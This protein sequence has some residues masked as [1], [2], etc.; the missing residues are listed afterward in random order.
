MLAFVLLLSACSSTGPRASTETKTTNADLEQA[1][2]NRL[3]ADTRLANSHIDVSADVDRNQITLSGT[4]P[5]EQLRMQAVEIA[6]A[7]RSGVIVVDKIEVKPPL[8]SRSDYTEDMARTTREK[9]KVLGD[10]VGTKLEDAWLYT[11]IMAKLVSDS[12]TP[13]R[14]IN[15]DVENSVVTLRGD[16]DS[17]AVRDEAERIARETDG[18]KRVINR[19]KVNA[20]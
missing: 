18:V 11:K 2:K 8:A 20:G 3:A 5:D 19:L 4:L 6:K 15:V 12:N 13:A 16:V 14:R 9:A 10:K 17:P 1:V 7:S